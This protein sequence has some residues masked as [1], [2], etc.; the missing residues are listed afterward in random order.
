MA[1]E[2][3][4]NDIK[5]VIVEVIQMPHHLA[6]PRRHPGFNAPETE[7]ERGNHQVL[8]SFRVVWRHT[9]RPI[10]RHKELLLRQRTTVPTAVNPL[11]RNISSNPS[12]AAST[13][14]S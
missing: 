6:D 14:K 11:R 5:R 13:V 1:G 9:S 7:V 3:L 4:S 12:V 10:T 8:I 2:D